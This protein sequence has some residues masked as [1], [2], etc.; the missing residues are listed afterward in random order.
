M[1]TATPVADAIDNLA[2]GGSTVLRGKQTPEEN[3][4]RGQCRRRR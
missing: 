4:S 2:E 1:T 3:R